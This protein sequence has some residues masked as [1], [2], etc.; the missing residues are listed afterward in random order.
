MLQKIDHKCVE[1]FEMWCWRRIEISWIDHMRDEVLH[2]VKGDRNILHT[3]KDREANW[4]GHILRRNCFLK[5][6]IK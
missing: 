3:L 1:S 4:I 5:H 6:I 2:G